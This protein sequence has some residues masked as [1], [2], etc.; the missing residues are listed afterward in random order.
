MPSKSKEVIV[1]EQFFAVRDRNQYL[2]MEGWGH[3][4]VYVICYPNHK[5]FDPERGTEELGKN[6]LTIAT[7]TE[8]LD[9][10]T[11]TDNRLTA[12]Y[13][14]EKL[15]FYNNETTV[16]KEYSR[17]RNRVRRIVGTDTHIPIP[18]KPTSSLSISS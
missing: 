4:T 14:E 15:V 2:E 16:L 12:T 10:L 1:S 18:D 11:L 5:G 7:V 9:Q 8:A 6:V 13:D 3:G 17:K